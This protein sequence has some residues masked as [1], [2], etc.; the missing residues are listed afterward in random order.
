MFTHRTI[1]PA[2]T[3]KILIADDDPVFRRLME[4]LLSKWGYEVII[5]C[6]GTEAWQAF[7]QPDPPYLAVLDWKMPGIDGV[8]L[9]RRIKAEFK[10]RAIYAILVT[11][12]QQPDDCVLALEAGADDFVAK[13]INPAEL[14]ARVRAGARVVEYQRLLQNMALED[15]LTGLGNRRA[16]AADI[17]RL[18][19]FSQRHGQAFAL[20]IADINAFKKINDLW[21]HDVGDLMLQKVATAL[22]NTFRA[23]DAVYRLG[24]DEFAVLF[25]SLAEPQAI[26][27]ERLLQNLAVQLKESP[28]EGFSAEQVK[29]SIGVACHSPAAPV[30]AAE[31]YRTADQNMYADKCRLMP[32]EAFEHPTSERL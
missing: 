5:A 22:R 11:A 19:N 7:Q 24:G 12:H 6:N 9:C 13:P 4:S 14:L 2:T 23:E 27:V 25:P 15:P 30:S 16:F 10:F 21:G 1:A 17:D 28:I 18:A 32:A 26:P 31:I 29:L 3:S 8:E 20:L